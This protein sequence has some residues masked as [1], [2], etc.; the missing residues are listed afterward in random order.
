MT[1]S[2][3]RA[4]DAVRADLRLLAD[5]TPPM[6]AELITRLDLA[7]AAE[8]AAPP[9]LISDGPATRPSRRR[10]PRLVVAFT[11][12]VMVLAGLTVGATALW[13]GQQQDT[14][15]D[16]SAASP[17]SRRESPA[18][19]SAVKDGT[20]GLNG[21]PDEGG[22]RVLRSGKDYTESTLREV[23]SGASMAEKSTDPV[24]D[25]LSSSPSAREDCFTAILGAYPGRVTLADFGYF[26][27]TPALVVRVTSDGAERFVAVGADCGVAG[28]DE[29]YTVAA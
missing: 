27:G 29:L 17:Q 1:E 11:T 20:E 28:P 25:R 4:A 15:G 21:G 13:R 5:A 16:S 12:G 8:I 24:L 23:G 22:P 26:K 18:P 10:W 9:A 3:D 2:P 14:A 19:T 6:P 7:L